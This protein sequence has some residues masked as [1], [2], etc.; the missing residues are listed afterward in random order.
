MKSRGKLLGGPY[1]QWMGLVPGGK[2]AQLAFPPKPVC[3]PSRLTEKTGRSVSP[4]PAWL[5][6]FVAQ[7]LDG[8]FLGRLV[9]RV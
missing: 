5:L 1:G 7:G 3:F 8:V 6:A 4:R 2:F 9:G